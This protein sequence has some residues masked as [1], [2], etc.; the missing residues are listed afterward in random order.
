MFTEFLF[1][2]HALVRAKYLA[3]STAAPV[4]VMR[5]VW[6]NFCIG[7]RTDKCVRA[8]GEHVAT[9]HR[10]GLV[11]RRCIKNENLCLCQ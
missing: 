5:N 9:V 6:G 7:L 10:S 2:S 11:E 3:A 1:E 8:Y 4:L